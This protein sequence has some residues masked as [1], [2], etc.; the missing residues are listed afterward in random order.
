MTTTTK[1]VRSQADDKGD[2]VSLQTGYDTGSDSLTRQEFKDEADLNILLGRFGV[3]QQVRQ[4]PRFI[5]ID[6]N[7]DLQSALAAV[8][9]ARRANYDIP[10]EL[11]AKYPDW[12]TLL[13]GAESGEY[14]KD[15]QALADRK[16]AEQKA[17][18]KDAENR[19][20]YEAWKARQTPNAPEQTPKE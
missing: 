10:Q 18:D 1:A 14:Q 6:Y 15:L 12:R 4:D 17:A 7:L 9:A 5:E 3:N 13:D 16:D 2:S 8:D 20:N 19:K 11:R